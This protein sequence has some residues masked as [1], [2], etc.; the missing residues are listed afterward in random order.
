M[1]MRLLLVLVSFVILLVACSESASSTTDAQPAAGPTT[2]TFA[3]ETSTTFADTTTTE[4]PPPATT[5]TLPELTGLAWEE[6]ASLG[7]FVTGIEPIGNEMLVATKDGLVRRLGMDGST[8]VLFDL[9]ALVRNSGE[10]GLLDLALHPDG[11]RLFVHFTAEGGDTILGELAMPDGTAPVELFRTGQPAGNHNGGSIEFGP[12]GMLYLALGD[13]GGA[14]DRFGNGQSLD[15]PLGAIHRFD[16]STEGAA[17]P[18][19]GNPFIDGPVPSMWAYGVRNPWR[20]SFTTGEE[21]VSGEP[22]LIVADVGQNAWE[23]VTVLPASAAGQ[24]LGWPIQE[25]RHCFSRTPCD[26]PGIQMAQ[27]EVAHGDGGTCSISGGEAYAGALIPELRGHYVFTDYCG[28]YL[29]SVDVRAPLGA[30]ATVVEWD[31]ERLSGPSLIVA[32][33]DGELLASGQ[34][35]RILRLTA[36]RGRQG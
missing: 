33:P 7:G 9:T 36:I 17:V 24:N 5:T 34:D 30:P 26:D 29:R 2:T 18:A 20:I 16:V 1:G 32:G 19:A 13:G 27:L 10:Q 25:G 21:T 31:V 4:A 22:Q 3:T 35:G 12:D 6:V 15:T 8:A 28:G 14:N 23:E 11:S